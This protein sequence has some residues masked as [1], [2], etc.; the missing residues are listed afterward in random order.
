[1]RVNALLDDAR[2]RTYINADVAAEL[3][4]HDK[5]QRITV[6]V[7]NDKTE[8]FETMSVEFQIETGD[9][10]TK[11]D[12]D[13]LTADKVTGDMCVI[14]W[15]KYQ[16]KWDYSY[17]RGLEFPR[18]GRHS[19]VDILIGMDH[20]ELHYAYQEIRGRPDE[21]VARLT[22]LEWTCVGKIPDSSEIC[23]QTRFNR[24]YFIQNQK[25]DNESD[26]I[27]CKFWEM[28]NFSEPQKKQSFSPEECI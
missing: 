14:N 13:A 1:M 25:S 12:V 28:E 6:E 16:N 23:V 22:P 4:L 5:P 26:K 20:S 3:G 17:L 11:T 15:R 8:S 7:L 2:T 27:L 21:P 18:V 19:V 9:G 24:T 10:R